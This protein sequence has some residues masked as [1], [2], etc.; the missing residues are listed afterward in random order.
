MRPLFLCFLFICLGC[1]VVP[2][3]SVRT[4]QEA[5]STYDAEDY[6]Q[7]AVLYE[8]LIEQGMRSGAV[9]YN[10]G[11]AWAKADEPVRAIAAYYLA[12]RY[13]PNGVVP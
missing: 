13:I 8:Q 3:E 6:R 10:L 7:A 12:K 1:N 9:Y 5:Q 11:N 2:T 4:F